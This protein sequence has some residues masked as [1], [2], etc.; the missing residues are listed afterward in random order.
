MEDDDNQLD[1]MMAQ[2]SCGMHDA[3]QLMLSARLQAVCPQQADAIVVSK[4]RNAV[5]DQSCGLWSHAR[6]MILQEGGSGRHL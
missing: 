6:R 1:V 4:R 5:A 2:V 3:H